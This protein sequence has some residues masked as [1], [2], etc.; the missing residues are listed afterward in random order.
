MSDVTAIGALHATRETGITVPG[1]L[2]IVGFDDIEHAPYTD[3]PLTTVH[4]PVREKGRTAVRLLLHE[5]AGTD[6]RVEHAR[7][8]VRLVIR[9]STGPVRRH[10]RR[11]ATVER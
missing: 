5:P 10:D 11:W 7:L 8:E 2:S 1:D 6:T 3:P 9:G 4:Q